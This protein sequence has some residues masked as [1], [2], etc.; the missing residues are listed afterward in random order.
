MLSLTVL[1]CDGSHSGAGGASSGYLL[2][3][4]ASSTSI[5]LDAGP[6][7]FAA[8]QRFCDPRSLTAVVLTHEHVD[9]C[10]D[11]DGFMTAARWTWGWD[12]APIDVVA[13]PGVRE[14]VHHHD[15]EVARWRQVDDGE[16][17]DVGAIHLTFSR[18]DH[19]PVTLAVRADCDG[20][21]FGYSADSGPGWTFEALGRG[22]DLALS[23]ATYTCEHEGKAGHMSARQAAIGANA[24]GARR[25]VLTHRWPTIAGPAVMAE[26]GEEF[27][28]PLHQAVPGIGFSL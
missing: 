6:G 4:W 5:W 7:T 16:E 3:H 14:R 13:A 25:L 19:P 1:G 27:G 11:L 28:G 21:A 22:L 8:L 26:A 17:L 10:S 9:H 20:S 12:R 18:T 23:E 15:P 24:A 2:R